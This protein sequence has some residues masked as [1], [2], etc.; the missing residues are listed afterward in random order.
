MFI[1]YK[2]GF[3]ILIEKHVMNCVSVLE[4]GKLV[5]GEHDDYFDSV[6]IIGV[7]FDI[8]PINCRVILSA[9]GRNCGFGWGYMSYGAWVFP[10]LANHSI[11]NSMQL[12]SWKIICVPTI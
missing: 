12:V 2:E 6:I 1:L 8:W 7:G 5:S 3:V 9:I 4:I 11:A 10:K